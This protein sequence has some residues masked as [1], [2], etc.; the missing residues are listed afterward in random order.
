LIT[1]EIWGNNY[2]D[3]I[4]KLA[5]F[6]AHLDAQ[7]RSAVRLIINQIHFVNLESA[8]SNFREFCDNERD[9]ECYL[10]K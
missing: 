10:R 6:G 4:E 2:L 3:R 7:L 5:F 1:R 9:F 8:P